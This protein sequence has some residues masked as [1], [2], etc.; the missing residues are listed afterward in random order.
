MALNESNRFKHVM[1]ASDA[2]A[3]V[4]VASMQQRR[5]LQLNDSPELYLSSKTVELAE[6]GEVGL[7]PLHGEEDITGRRRTEAKN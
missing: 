6:S 7:L 2:G 5:Q 4:W 3:G 1:T